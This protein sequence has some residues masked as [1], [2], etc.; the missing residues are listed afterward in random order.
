MGII[1]FFLKKEKGIKI[2]KLKRMR[3]SLATAKLPIFIMPMTFL[4]KN[5]EFFL[6]KLPICKMHITNTHFENAYY[7]DIFAENFLK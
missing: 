5:F 3:I 7:T 2:K 4:K 6:Y 1:F